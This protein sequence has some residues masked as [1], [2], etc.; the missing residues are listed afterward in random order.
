MHNIL[1]PVPMIT[2]FP[3]DRVLCNRS[4]KWLCDYR[5]WTFLFIKNYYK[6]KIVIV[7]K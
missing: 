3:D 5:D 6:S 4:F 7:I 2:K 1:I